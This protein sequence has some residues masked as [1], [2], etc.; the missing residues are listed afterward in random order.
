MGSLINFEI[1][2]ANANFALR[3]ESVFVTAV[4]EHILELSESASTVLD[5][6]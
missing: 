5:Y 4:S 3:I 2:G 1:K 6:V